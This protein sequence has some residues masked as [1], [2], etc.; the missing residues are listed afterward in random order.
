MADDEVLKLQSHL[1]LLREEY[2]KLQN[3]LAN[4]ERKCQV[5]LAQ[6]G[7]NGEAQDG[8]VSRL[9]KFISDL[10]DKE[11]Y[12]DLVIQLE[13]HHDVKA[14]KF[15]LSARSDTWGVP[16]LSAVS[17]LDFT[18]IQH[19]V[20]YSLI[21][22]IYTNE[23]NIKAHDSFL[24]E[25][26]RAATRFKLEELR[27]RCENGLMSFVNMKNCI[28]FY[29]TAEE[30]NAEVLK[31]HCSELISNHWNEFTSEDFVSMP[32]PLLYEMFKAKTE[33]PLHT[34]I[35]TEREDVVFL[36]LIEYDSE[37]SVK[38][39]EVDNKGDL[40][41]DLALKMQQ[42][43][44]AQNLVLN[45]AD[46]DRKDNAGKCLL[47]KAI[48]RGDES[49][50]EFL[51]SNKCNVNMVTHLDKETPLHRVASFDPKLT[52]KSVMEGMVRIAKVLLNN[53]S[54]VNAQD[55]TGRSCIEN[56]SLS[57]V[58]LTR[59]LTEKSVME[60]MVRT[61]K[62]LLNNNSDVNAQ[63][64]TGSTPL[65]NAI[66]SKNKEVFEALLISGKINLEIKNSEGHTPLWVAL[67]QQAE[68]PTG[69]EPDQNGPIY[70]ETS[71]AAQLIKAGASP[72]AV[73]PESGNSL[74][75]MAAKLSYQEA[76]IFLAKH[77]AAVS[78]SN[79]K[80]VTP[81]HMACETGLTDLVRVLL[82][83]GANPNAQTLRPPTSSVSM[84]ALGI[85][86]SKP[87]I[88]QQTPLH[89][90][91]SKGYHAIVQIF[92]DIK[93]Q[94]SKSPTAAGARLL[95]N[96][97]V[98]DSQGQ[99]VLG[100]ALWN[101]MLDMADQL[102]KCGANI[103][104]KNADG[105]TLLHQAIEAQDSSSALFLMDHLADLESVSPDGQTV[106]QH[107]ISRHLPQVVEALCERGV[108][109]D[110]TDIE[111]NCPLWQ[112]LD[113]GQEDIAHT[114]VKYGCDVD[115][116][117]Q[118]S[119]GYYHTL[120]HRAL[121]QN[122]EAMAC[123]LIRSGC[124]KNS[125]RKPGP[126]GEG[127]DEGRDLQTPLHL[128]CSWG[129]ELTVQCLMELNAD[130][131]AQDAEGKAPIH[132]AIENQFPVVISLLLS[133]PV[134]QLNVDNKGRNFL[135]TAIQNKD[136]ESVLFLMSVNADLNSRTQDSQ[137]LTPL[138]LAVLTGSEILVRNLLLAGALVDERTKSCETALLLGA[139]R[140]C[141]AICSILIDSGA[142]VNATDE[143]LNNALHRA[144]YNGNVSTVKVLLIES[145]I[146]AE[147]MNAKGQNPLHVLGQYGRDAAAAAMFE[148]IK[149]TIPDYPIDRPDN[150]GNTVLL[151][152]YLNGNGQLCRALVRAGACLGQLNKEG[153]SI[154]N[155]PVATKQL[156]FKLLD[157]LSKEPPWSD[158]EMCLECGIKFS[159]KTRKHHC[160]H[161]GR[162][163]C[164]KCSSKDMPIV[165]FNIS[166][167]TRVCDICF[168]V[169]SIGGQY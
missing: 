26:L 147:A 131:N 116:W 91:L 105:M 41:L 12:S 109:K 141:S 52:E 15:I 57:T 169:L 111:G 156:L 88:F 112:A 79:F 162:L 129:L 114:L 8:F 63:D 113:S 83:C 85:D 77:G 95:P 25:L 150:D 139:S 106:I 98:K 7:V 101:N 118:S 46:I 33:Y 28:K 89:V 87:E 132:V 13:G 32:A 48:Q 47:Y 34:A 130:V 134:L 73:E 53:N 75:H 51:I 1:S 157:M 121:D 20:A 84:A 50:A 122:N 123:F 22:W 140:D 36:Y 58:S 163:L 30:M 167:P 76:A 54:D 60:G 110:S 40:P 70:G 127:G 166:K 35:R 37:L 102:I 124:D 43:S 3:K 165:K 18:D 133:H 19:D 115:M 100:L 67:Q 107:A 64:A 81:L 21:R 119:E 137:N 49:A 138:H 59:Q 94:L 55:A 86:D 5:A 164:S 108:N 10:F 62:V 2:V 6:A 90:A 65:H 104:E 159:I 93:A 23:I 56:K 68:S 82:D 11:Q 97:N 9:L 153:L 27:K 44:M 148:L 69:E 136:I 29:Q 96:F 145:Q 61:A 78:L 149:E 24:L 80:G 143:N 72:D 31:N 14:H 158:G 142:D 155:A 151:L 117:M 92:L 39:N 128:A 152:A 38:V 135:H 103:N 168:D 125:P 4:T 160:R 126:S 17:V 99:T 45:K 71:L 66:I 161:C 120:L 144:I 16:D 154:F 74:L 146:N 42:R